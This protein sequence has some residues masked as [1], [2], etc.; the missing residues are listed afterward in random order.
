MMKSSILCCCLLWLASV[1]APAQSRQ[2]EIYWID[3]EGGAATLI[4]TP[5]GQ[6]LLADSGNPGSDD[7][8]AKRIFEVAKAAGLTKI[9]MLLTTHFHSDHVGGAPALAKLIPI[10]KFYDH[11]DSIEMINERG[12]QLWEAYR[13]L[14]EGKRVIMKPGDRIPLDG[15]EVTVVTSNGEIVAKPAT[16]GPQNPYCRDALP[17]PMDR[18]EN[19]RSLGFLLTYG[20]FRFLDLGDLTWDQE[21]RLACP[22]NRIGRV[23]LFQAT[24]H[25]FFGNSSGAPAHVWSV[26]PQVVV[27]NNGARKGLGAEAYQTL[28]GIPGVEAIWQIHRATQTDKQHNTAETMIANTEETPA[29]CRGHWIKA[30]ISQDGKFTLT[31]GRNNFSKTYSAK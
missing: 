25:G 22:V 16:E 28:K 23:T 5:T 7:R 31:N 29:E 4:I 8:D 15:L 30:S 18:S 3:V 26:Q 10:E 6:S 27:V 13:P 19:G 21:L 2:L 11:G 14:T 9:D 12:A 17:K 24:H 20:K 1:A